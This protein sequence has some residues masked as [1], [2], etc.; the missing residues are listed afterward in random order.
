MRKIIEEVVANEKK[1]KKNKKGTN[2]CKPQKKD[3]LDNSLTRQT[4]SR[5]IQDRELEEVLSGLTTTIK[6]IGC[7]GAGYEGPVY[8][9]RRGS[10]D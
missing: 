4:I 2:D 8:R 5:G 10:E 6:V 3:N 7:G 1:G 9:K